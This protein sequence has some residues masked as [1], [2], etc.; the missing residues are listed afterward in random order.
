MPNVYFSRY[1]ITTAF[2]YKNK[3]DFFEIGL[4]SEKSTTGRGYI[5]KFL[6]QGVYIVD[7]STYLTGELVKY[8]PDGYEDVVNEDENK[9]EFENIHNKVV[10]VSKF[11]ID[12]NSSIIIH[13]DLPRI[14]SLNT[15]REKFSE[16]IHKNYDN[17]LTEFYM[18]PITEQY[19]FINELK[20]FRT[21]NKITISLQPSNPRFGEKW[22]RIDKR[23]QENNIGK[24]K[25]IQESKDT[26]SSLVLDGETESKL[27]MSEDGYGESNAVGIDKN[28]NHKRISTKNVKKNI[29]SSI[30]N[31]EITFEN[32]LNSSYDILKQITDRVLK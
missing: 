29:F 11:I 31:A 5:F 6:N 10:G 9:I 24:Y 1:H 32:I 4:R 14:I 17:F 25:E 7:N 22:K 28:G 8:R 23:L 26:S 13:T 15:F 2:N 21:I 19:S 12:I 16:L 27:F 3:Q 18:T 20:S 30:A